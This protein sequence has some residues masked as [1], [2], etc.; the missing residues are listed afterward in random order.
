LGAALVVSCV[1]RTEDGPSMRLCSGRGV[2]IHAVPVRLIELELGLEGT[3]V[4][5]RDEPG[6]LRGLHHASGGFCRLGGEGDVMQ[7]CYVWAGGGSE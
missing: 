3:G 7:A 2:T 5:T 4:G 6:V 1:V